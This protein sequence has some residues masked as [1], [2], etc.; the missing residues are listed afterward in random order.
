MNNSGSLIMIFQ[1]TENVELKRILND[2]FEKSLNAFLNTMNGTIY[3]GVND[4]G[5][6]IGVD[7]L[8]DNLKKI[9]DIITMQVVPNPQEFVEIGT[10]YI[11]GKHVIE[12]KVKK[13]N[14]LY[15]IKKYGRSGSGCYIRVGTT[16][17]SMTEEQIE[18]RY[19]ES[20]NIP[21]KT[22]KEDES[23]RQDL[24]FKQFKTLLTFKNIH[25]N[26]QTF[27]VNFNLRNSHGKYNYIAFLVSDQNDTSI[28]VV[29][30]NGKT[31]SDF[32]SRKEFENGCIFKQM[33]DALEYSLNVLN[34]VQT[35]IVGGERV[36]TPY[37][38]AVAFRE[39]WFNAVCHNL[40]VERIPPAIYGYDDRV[41]IISQGVLKSGMT[42]DEFFMGISKPINGEFAKIFT[43]MRYMEQSGRGVPTI[44][45]KYGKGVYHFGSSFIQCVLPYNIIDKDKQQRLNGG[46]A[47][48]PIND[49]IDPIN[50]PINNSDDPINDKN[51]PINEPIDP[52]NDPINLTQRENDILNLI[53]ND[54]KITYSQIATNVGISVATVKRTVEVLK[55]KGHII[56][57]TANKNGEWIIGNKTK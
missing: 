28:K 22:M 17:R 24:T 44:V 8:D 51:E 54:K 55:D 7:N 43:Q 25:Y 41:E 29:R 15:Y 37:F 1:E 4:D 12:I 53:L 27:E 18:K 31:K 14:A 39:A 36:D 57:K 50:E 52:I 35:N 34:I 11:E 23:P 20:I 6:I 49:T 32:I 48:E 26:E 33:E 19:I 13:G 10:K 56:G 40:W 3:I 5:S 16:C 30:F 47:D 46:D 9:S 45:E 42:Q 2:T 38:D 21:E